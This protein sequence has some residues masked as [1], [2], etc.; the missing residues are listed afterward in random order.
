[1]KNRT[2]PAYQQAPWRIQVQWIGLFLLILL[3]VASVSGVYLSVSANAATSGREIQYL[4]AKINNDTLAIANLSS[5]LANLTSAA[6]MDQRAA[7]LG[8]QPVEA[9][10]ETYVVVPGYIAQD[11]AQLAPPLGQV[12]IPPP[13]LQPSYTES[14][15]DWIMQMLS[16]SSSDQS[17]VQQ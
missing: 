12:M 3:L 5:E 2:M 15:W 9:E 8:F 14:L 11:T 1:M 17:Q 10:N 6:Q 7:A 4:Q 13:L 16:S